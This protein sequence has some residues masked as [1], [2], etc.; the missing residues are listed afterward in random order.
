LFLAAPAFANF[1]PVAVLPELLMRAV[2]ADKIL[3][4]E[5]APSNPLARVRFTFHL[6][7]KLTHFES[8]VAH[9]YPLP[10]PSGP[11]RAYRLHAFFG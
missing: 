2:G 4:A 6:A 9:P 10:G 7:E 8:L 5:A 1:E 3:A 11:D